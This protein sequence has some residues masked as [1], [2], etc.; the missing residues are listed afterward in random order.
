M[1]PGPVLVLR[2]QPGADET[3][4]RL[5]A[6]GHDA[7]ALPLL[8]RRPLP[9][10][11]AARRCVDDLDLFD[12]IVCVSPAAV[13]HGLPRIT[14]RWPQ[15]PL[16]PRWIAV[17]DATATTLA[18]WD[19]AAVVPDDARTEGLLTL[20]ALADAERV[21]IV[22]GRGGR[23]DLAA[24]LA[25]RGQQVEHLVV[26]ER[27]AQRVALP[28]AADVSALVATSAEVVD[29]L[30]ASGGQA[31]FGVPLLVP[32]ARVADHAARAGFER[33]TRMHGASPTA[34]AEAIAGLFASDDAS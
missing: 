6:D 27:V 21:L 12:A 33:V 19:V 15:L 2:P 8:D 23:E 26:Y 1:N 10:D 16:R 28:E 7:R 5:K 14:D 32:S 17:G 9:E 31:L 18:R 4:A 3:V 22:R 25:A 20:E 11:A 13:S 29:A 30:L 34:T 24:E